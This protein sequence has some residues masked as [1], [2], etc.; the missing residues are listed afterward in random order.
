MINL[1]IFLSFELE[2]TRLLLMQFVNMTFDSQS[3]SRI[4]T[5]ISDPKYQIQR[6]AVIG[7]GPLQPAQANE[8]RIADPVPGHCTNADFLSSPLSYPIQL[9]P[10]EQVRA[11]SA[12]VRAL[13]A[14]QVPVHVHTTLIGASSPGPGTCTDAVVTLLISLEPTATP[15][16]SHQRVQPPARYRSR[17]V[18]RWLWL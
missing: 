12:A 16:T 9:R 10:R 7:R 13:Q 18:S 17:S 6:P 2:P 3:C 15:V 5:A 4:A 11:P 14:C 8:M 1:S